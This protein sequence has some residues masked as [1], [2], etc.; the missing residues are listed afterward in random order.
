MLP[1]GVEFIGVTLGDE[2][3]TTGKVVVPFTHLGDQGGHVVGLRLSDSDTPTE[4][5][6]KFNPLSR[7]IDYSEER[8]ETRTLEGS[9]AQ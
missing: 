6:I 7:S 1:D 9:K 5:W 3:R 4:L 8:P 2:E